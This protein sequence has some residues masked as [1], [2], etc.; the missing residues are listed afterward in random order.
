MQPNEK[1]CYSCTDTFIDI[2]FGF[3]Y[4]G[5]ELS[6]PVGSFSQLLGGSCGVFLDA[7][8][9]GARLLD[10]RKA[11]HHLIAFPFTRFNK[12]KLLVETARCEIGRLVGERE[13]PVPVLPR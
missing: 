4:N 1:E 5:P 9:T 13:V 7:P 12:A 8:Q 6:C 3:Y 11:R 2:V 10:E